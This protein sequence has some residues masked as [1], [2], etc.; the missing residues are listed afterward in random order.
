M[1]Y[2]TKPVSR[3]G[4]RNLSKFARKMFDLTPSEPFPV[5][6]ALENLSSIFEGTE[7]QVVEDSELPAEVF[8][9]VLPKA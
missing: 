3:M 4:I 1:D 7:Y 6:H 2:L 5:L 9:L 8:C